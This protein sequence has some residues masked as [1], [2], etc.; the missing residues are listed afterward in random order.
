MKRKGN[1]HHNLRHN[2]LIS[3]NRIGRLIA[4]DFFSTQKLFSFKYTHAGSL[5]NTT[6]LA[7]CICY[8]LFNIPDKLSPVI[9]GVVTRWYRYIWETLSFPANIL[10]NRITFQNKLHCQ[11]IL[12]AYLQKKYYLC[13]EFCVK[14]IINH[15]KQLYYV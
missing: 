10:L 2:L 11:L 12:F 7:C 3:P 13:A 5:V 6:L 1:F 4:S 8:L 15:K 9:I 14:T